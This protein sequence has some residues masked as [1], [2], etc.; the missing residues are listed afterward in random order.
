MVG[1]PNATDDDGDPVVLY[2]SL[3]DRW[4][5]IQFNLRVTAKPP[6]AHRRIQDR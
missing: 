1:I 2:D 6:P 3:A 4:V 5:V